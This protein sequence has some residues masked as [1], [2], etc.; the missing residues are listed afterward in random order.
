MG[1]GRKGRI[2]SLYLSEGRRAISL[3]PFEMRLEAGGRGAGRQK[4][5]EGV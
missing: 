5:R 4:G 2:N 1:G 3:A